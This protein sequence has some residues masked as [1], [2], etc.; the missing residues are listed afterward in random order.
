MDGARARLIAQRERGAAAADDRA[1]VIL[2]S[3]PAALA[4]ALADAERHRAEAERL[5]SGGRLPVGT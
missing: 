2:P 3:F 4:A 1:A 5:R